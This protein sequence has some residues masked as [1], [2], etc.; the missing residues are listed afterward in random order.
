VTPFGP[1][2]RANWH[3]DPHITYLNHG[4]VGATPIAITDN[5]N[6]GNP[7]KPDTMGVIVKAIEGM[8]EACRALEFPVV[9]GNVSLYNETDGVGIP[10][11]PVVGGIGL[12]DNL[13]HIA[14]LKGAQPGD[15]LL[16]IGETTGHLGASAYAR[17][18]LGLDGPA[19]GNA[20]RVDLALEVKHASII[21]K[22][23]AA[24][25]VN[26]VHDV[27]E[28]GIA[29]AAAEMALAAGVGVTFVP[30]REPGDER[31]TPGLFGEDQ[32][33]YLVA[34]SDAQNARWGVTG[35]VPSALGHFGG[36]AVVMQTGWGEALKN[37]IVPLSKL[38]AAHEGW[39]PGYMNSQG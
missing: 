8:A 22:L 1:A 12:I 3:L 38:R 32:A 25:L 18:I 26:A 37:H 35:T 33:R 16:V 21:R 29:C 31:A 27:S 34:V 5:L 13:D 19:A 6:F 10:P 28:G 30:D 23:I 39:L 11:T 17:T 2:W 14:T 36:D 7:E 24:G 9:S 4:T 20:P 15:K